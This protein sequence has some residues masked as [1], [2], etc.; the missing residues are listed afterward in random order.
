M[1]ILQKNVNF[2]DTPWSSQNGAEGPV[3]YLFQKV[4]FAEKCQICRHHLE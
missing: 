3:K 1:S 2:A 4:N